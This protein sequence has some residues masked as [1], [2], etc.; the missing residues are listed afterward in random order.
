MKLL[1]KKHYDPAET[2]AK[3]KS[4]IIRFLLGRGFEYDRVR[5]AMSK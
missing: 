5:E 2:D 3:E 1:E 4:R